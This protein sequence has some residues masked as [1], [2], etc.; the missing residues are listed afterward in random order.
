MKTTGKKLS[1]A[2]I[3][4]AEQ[5]CMESV[6]EA[7]GQ[8]IVESVKNFYRKVRRVGQ[9][10]KN[11]GVL[12]SGKDPA[13]TNGNSFLLENSVVKEDLLNLFGDIVKEARRAINDSSDQP[14]Q[15]TRGEIFS[16]WLN[17]PVTE[18]SVLMRRY[19]MALSENRSGKF[20]KVLERVPKNENGSRKIGLAALNAM[21][22]EEF[23]IAAAILLGSSTTGKSFNNWGG[24]FL[25]ETKNAG[26]Q[27]LGALKSVDSKIGELAT[28]IPDAPKFPWERRR[29]KNA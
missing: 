25:K 19:E 5:L 12:G 10:T 15:R 4:F 7:G 29:K 26:S 1:A 6:K 23:E 2:F 9:E 28:K 18:K 11:P 8:T 3:N 21:S 24:S 22:D 20:L 14:R 27:A 13:T 17:M 16:D